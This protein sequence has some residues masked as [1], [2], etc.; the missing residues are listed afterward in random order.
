MKIINFILSAFSLLVAITANAQV[1]IGTTSP[2]ASAALD[3]TS[4]TKGLLPP[5]MTEGQR[6][7]IV[8]PTA[9]L[10]IWCSN[11][12]LSGQIQVYNGTKWTNMTGG[13]PESQGGVIAYIF[14]PGDPGYIPGEVHGLIAA[15][16]D[17]GNSPWGCVFNFIGGTSTALGT[18]QANTTAIIN[19][20]G[21]IGIAAQICNDLTL[22]GYSDWYLP[23]KDELNKLFLN[24]I[25]IG[26]FSDNDYYWSSSEISEDYAWMQGFQIYDI[27]GQYEYPKD[28]GLRFRAVRSF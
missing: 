10:M 15:P 14:Q 4:T 21:A 16:Y 27:G 25:A 13:A 2:I 3:I 23:S 8:T 1:G 26:G 5:R 11:C 12:G 20:C 18:G 7:T 22:N 17:Q 19:E 24:R 6:N 28:Y 9:G